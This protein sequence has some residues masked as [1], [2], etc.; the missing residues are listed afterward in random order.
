MERETYE[1][2]KR[3][4]QKRS[5]RILVAQIL[6]IANQFS[7]YEKIWFPY[8]MDFRG[9]I[10][11]IPVL[12]QPQGSDLAKGLL[13]FAEGKEVDENSVKWLKIHGAN[14]YGYDKE[15]YENR[16]RWI[17]ERADEIISYAENPLQNRGWTE[18]DKP[19]Q[20]L[21]WCFEYNDYLSNPDTFRTHIPIQLDGTCNGLQHYSALLRDPVGGAAVN[22]TNALKPNDIY[23]KL[24]RN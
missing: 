9:R 17:D 5:V 1:T 21:A 15:S 22:L 14:V 8:Q 6:R 16:I 3:N 2:H 19:F 23:A 13:R 4:V 12:L 11:P 20:F 10:Y 24:Q 7:K 18:A